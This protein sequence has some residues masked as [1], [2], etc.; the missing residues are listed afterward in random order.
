[1]A[2]SDLQPKQGKIDIIVEVVDKSDVREFEKFG[3]KGRVCNCKVKDDTGEISLTLWNDDID[4]V[5]V[6]DRVQIKNGYVSE[7]QGEK[8]LSTG[9]FGSLEQVGK[10]NAEPAPEKA[11]EEDKKEDKEE[12]LEDI[13]GQIKELEKEEEKLEAEE[14]KQ[15]EPEPVNNDIHDIAEEEVVEDNK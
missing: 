6:G 14:K 9:K 4:K 15:V 1:M 13:G 12:E 8:Q 7:Y 2:I 10:E 11:A 3:K 5:N